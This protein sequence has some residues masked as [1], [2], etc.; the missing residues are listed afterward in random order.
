M[1]IQPVFSFGIFYIGC[2]SRS[3]FFLYSRYLTNQDG[4]DGSLLLPGWTN[5]NKTIH[6]HSFNVTRVFKRFADNTLG[7]V[8]G[9][10]WYSG[11]IFPENYDVY[12][13]EPSLLAELHINY[14]NGSKTIIVSDESWKVSTGPIVYSDLLHGEVLYENR[15]FENCLRFDFNDTNWYSPNTEL[16]NKTVKLVSDTITSAVVSQ[17]ISV[18]GYGR[19]SG[20]VF[21]YEM[22]DILTGGVNI[23]IRSRSN[24]RVQIRYAEVIYPNGSIYTANHK[25]A[26]DTDVIVLNGKLNLLKWI[27]IVTLLNLNRFF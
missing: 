3:F 9:P 17:L 8:V 5:Y 6:F 21:V 10:A 16:V 7:F 19:V 20:N 1:C 14:Q 15:H 25:S 12:G 27:I 11:Y 22:N 26:L 4:I 2:W 13:N 18:Q 24:L 23:R